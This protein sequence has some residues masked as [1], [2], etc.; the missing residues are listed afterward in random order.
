M[1]EMWKQ[2]W[3]N[4]LLRLVLRKED[5]KK[6]QLTGWRVCCPGFHRGTE[7]YICKNLFNFFSSTTL[8]QRL[9]D[10]GLHGIGTV[11]KDQ[12]HTL[13]LKADKE[14]KRGDSQI[15][16]HNNIMVCKWMDDKL[17]HMIL[18]PVDGF[19]TMPSLQCRAK[20][21]ATRTVQNCPT[22]IKMC[23]AHIRGVD[24]LDQQV[25]AYCIGCK[26]KLRFYL[27]ILFWP[28]FGLKRSILDVRLGSKCASDLLFQ[29]QR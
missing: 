26:S 14:L 23:N 25:T 2:Y 1:D 12:N 11:R 13:A 7:K 29:S 22:V 6:K 9:Y 19:N 10:N 8:I 28:V 5:Q 16:Y 4:I 17:V 15:L 20:G 21:S 24:L 3:I 18:S 27:R